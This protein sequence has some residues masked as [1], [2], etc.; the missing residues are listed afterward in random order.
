MLVYIDTLFMFVY[1]F[2]CLG[3]S[4]V[5][6]RFRLIYKLEATRCELVDLLFSLVCVP[7]KHQICLLGHGAKKRFVKLCPTGPP[8]LNFCVVFNQFY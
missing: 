6:K 8:L 3:K 7:G 4:V 1:L 5:P 2:V